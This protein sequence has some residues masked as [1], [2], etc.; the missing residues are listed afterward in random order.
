[1]SNQPQVTLIQ[2]FVSDTDT[3][4]QFKEQILV[5]LRHHFLH[6]ATYIL[7]ARQ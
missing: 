4:H 3:Q 7:C 6:D 5:P 1:M 2:A